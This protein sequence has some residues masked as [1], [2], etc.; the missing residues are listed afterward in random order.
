MLMYVMAGVN[1]MDIITITNEMMW[2]Q[3]KKKK[4][5]NI[6]FFQLYEVPGVAKS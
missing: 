4:K 5:T 6:E 1:L 2:T 3:K